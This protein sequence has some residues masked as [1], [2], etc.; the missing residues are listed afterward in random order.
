MRIEAGRCGE[1]E[2]PSRASPLPH[3]TDFQHGN[4]VECGS[5]LARER[6]RPDTENQRSCSDSARALMMGLSR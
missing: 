2:S 6:A 5:G 1:V 4:A 3:S